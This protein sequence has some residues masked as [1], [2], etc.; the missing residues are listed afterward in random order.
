MSHKPSEILKIGLAQISP[1]WLNREQTIS[2][3]KSFIENASKKECDV[4]VFGEALLPGYPFWVEH[5]GGARFNS[6]LQK[7]LFSH[8]LKESVNISK[9]HLSTIQEACKLNKITTVLGC[10]ESAHDRGGH[11]AYCSLVYIDRKGVI[12]NVHRKLMPTYEER[13]VWAQGDGHGLQV[14]HEGLFTIGTLNCWENW[15][16][17]VR[18]AL[19]AQG[20]DLRIASW[21]GSVRNTGDITRFMAIESRSFIVSVS[22]LLQKKDIPENTPFYDE[23]MESLPDTMADGGSCVCGPDGEWLLK[24]QAGIEDLF[25]VTLNHEKIRCE[26]QNFDPSGHYSRPDVTKLILNRTRQSTVSFED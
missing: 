8:Y 15:M 7:K 20:E 24:P 16:P 23:L 5:T 9:G 17:L 10:I 18:S 22:G 12:R 2:K 4:V 1:V 19:Y 14:Q 21:P 6:T 26:R 3:I 11:S 25:T 13:L